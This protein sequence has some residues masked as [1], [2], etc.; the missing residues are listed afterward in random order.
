MFAETNCGLE[1]YRLLMGISPLENA[2]KAEYRD[3]VITQ[4]EYMKMQFDQY[5]CV[6]QIVFIKKGSYMQSF[7]TGIYGHYW[8]SQGNRDGYRFNDLMIKPLD[9]DNVGL[10]MTDAIVSFIVDRRKMDEDKII[11]TYD[12]CKKQT[13]GLSSC[14]FLRVKNEEDFVKA[15]R[16]NDRRVR[17]QASD[18][19]FDSRCPLKYSIQNAFD[20]NPATSYVEN[21]EDDLMKIVL[22]K[23]SVRK[24]LE[25]KFAIINGYAS[26]SSLYK[27]NNRSKFEFLL[28]KNIW[29]KPLGCIINKMK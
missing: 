5:C 23:I 2:Y 19:L 4:D 6:W 27:A 9:K 15:L 1:F 20:G 14:E 13:S 17:I 21:T 29:K 25:V 12:A 8:T 11:I 16:D 28:N 10:F 26:S 18:Y 24:D 7:F 22:R 3:K